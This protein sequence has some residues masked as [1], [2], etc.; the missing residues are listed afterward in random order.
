MCMSIYLHLRQI[1][2]RH[3][4][5]T[6]FGFCAGCLLSYKKIARRF[7]NKTLS[8]PY[9]DSLKQVKDIPLLSQDRN[10]RPFLQ[11]FLSLSKNEFGTPIKNLLNKIHESSTETGDVELYTNDTHIEFRGLLLVLLDRL[12]RVLDILV[13]QDTKSFNNGDEEKSL[14]NEVV[15][16]LRLYGYGLL[17]VICP[18]CGRRIPTG[19]TQQLPLKPLSP[20][21]FLRQSSISKG[22]LSVYQVLRN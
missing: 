4:Y 19:T 20:Q 1:G 9:V 15:D 12:K 7:N 10:E 17:L 2:P 21:S 16:K 5:T 8:G 22:R 13:F 11:D 14:F 3:H 18:S 6:I